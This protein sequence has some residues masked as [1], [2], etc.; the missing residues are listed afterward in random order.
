[1]S[2]FPCDEAG[3][4]EWRMISDVGELET[5]YCPGCGLTR[6]VDKVTGKDAVGLLVLNEDFRRDD[7]RE[8]QL[9][10]ALLKR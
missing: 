7:E 6:L 9:A 5:H 8:Q 4:H 3:G 2:A 10:E 1:V